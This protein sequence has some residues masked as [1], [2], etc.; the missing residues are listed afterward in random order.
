MIYIKNIKLNNF[1]CYKNSFFS[2]ERGINVIIGN[3][4]VGKTSL[5]EAVGMIGT[6]KSFRTNYDKDL[7]SINNSFYFVSFKVEDVQDK[8]TCTVNIGSDGKQKKVTKN[9]KPYKSLSDFI[10]M[11]KVVVF[12]PE[13]LKIIKGD[14]KNK[15]RFL[16]S[17]ISSLNKNYLFAL[18][19]YNKVLKERN[20]LLKSFQDSNVNFTLLDVYTEKII[21]EGKKI[22]LYR[23]EF[24]KKM[25]PIVCDKVANIS[26]NK[27]QAEIIYKPNVE[28]NNIE[29]GFKEN[30]KNDLFMKTTTIGPHRD[31]FEVIINKERASITAS[32]GQI[33]T[34][35]LSLKISLVDLIKETDS[36]I[37]IILDDVF[38]ELDNERQNYLMKLLEKE[39]QI[40][41]TTTLISN[42]DEEIIKKS[43][44]ISIDKAGD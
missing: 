33:R 24:I 4:A 23:E 41:I 31:D 37:I 1:R 15:R 8:N 3:N 12:S 36:N 5:V 10:G 16:D 21:E 6:G 9:E 11:I 2:F 26:F 39:N 19:N 38:S 40:F 18:I 34:L 13:D 35:A 17:S 20:E 44:I 14:P 7:I 32:Q 27:E 28:Y 42:I 29:K 30:L 22:I 25:N 43:N